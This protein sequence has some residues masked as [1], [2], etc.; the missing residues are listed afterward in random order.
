MPDPSPFS[1]G[2]AFTPS[3]IVTSAKLAEQVDQI[4]VDY[5][6]LAQAIGNA[7]S[8]DPNALIRFAHNQLQLRNQETG[9]W[10]AIWI[11]GAAGA[12]ELCIGVG[13]T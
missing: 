1:S 8:T 2:Y 3:E 9:L 4:K 13:T 5:P 10:H 7:G 11:T 12:E 6:E